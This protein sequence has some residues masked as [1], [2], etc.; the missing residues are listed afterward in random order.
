MLDVPDVELDPVRPRQRRAT[1]NLRP[2]GQARPDVEP[3]ALPLGVRLDLVAQRRPRP[4]QAHL[5]AHDVPELRQL[6]DRGAAKD[7]AD[8]R[9]PAVARVDGVAGTLV[10]GVDDHRAELEQLEVLA[11]LADTGLAEEDGAAVLDLDR[12]RGGS[13][14]RA[15]DGEPEGMR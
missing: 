12:D 8:A 14:H 4:D 5:A 2:A 7:P 1:V 10:L 11:V 6:V 3:L 13:E 15:R 9:D